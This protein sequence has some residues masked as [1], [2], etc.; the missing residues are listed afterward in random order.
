MP[1]LALVM[2]GAC[3]GEDSAIEETT[4]PAVDRMT[5]QLEWFIGLLNDPELSAGDY[6]SRFV[7]GYRTRVPLD[8][9]LPMVNEMGRG[10]P[11]WLDDLEMSGDTTGVAVIAAASGKRLTV[12]VEIELE[13]RGRF[14]NLVV[15]PLPR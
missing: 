5:A 6:E 13:G 4:V 12:S 9:F 15:Q 2:L 3:S 7:P 1:A 8:T 11:W 14:V 10:G